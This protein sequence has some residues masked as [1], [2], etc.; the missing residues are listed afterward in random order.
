MNR[1]TGNSTLGDQIGAMAFVDELRAQRN[2][3]QDHL[4]LP[5]R[6]AEVAE[7]IRTYYQHQGI[8]CDDELVEQGVRE[9]FGRR[10]RFEAPELRRFDTLLAKLVVNNQTVSLILTTVVFIIYLIFKLMPDTP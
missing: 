2:K 3:L 6:R 4:D 10:L 5:K 8:D 9:F 1:K 7:R